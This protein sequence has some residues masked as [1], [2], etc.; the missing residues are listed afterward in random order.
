ML[1]LHTN[2]KHLVK[3]LAIVACVSAIG[4]IAPSGTASAAVPTVSTPAQHVATPNDGAPGGGTH[5]MITWTASDDVGIVS[6]TLWHGARVGTSTSW[7]PISISPTVRQ[8]N[9]AVNDNA[10][11][12]FSVT[13][14][15]QEGN[16][17][18]SALSPLFK[19]SIYQSSAATSALMGLSAEWTIRTGA[20]YSE[21]STLKEIEGFAFS[22]GHTSPVNVLNVAAIGTKGPQGGSTRVL[23]SGTSYSVTQAR[24]TA[25][26]QA[27]LA[28]KKYD[29]A[30]RVT[31]TV[32]NVPGSAGYSDL[33]A[34]VY[35]EAVN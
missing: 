35:F 27:V 33:D 19:R 23:F 30:Q 13:V 29:T 3:R 34:I 31:T 4:V 6:Q 18:S 15:D 20:S 26:H 16:S 1:K 7:S 25:L 32:S 2:A 21:G 5:A 8:A 22:A 28:Q 24:S 10:A 17:R 11:H 9:V 14:T 12:T